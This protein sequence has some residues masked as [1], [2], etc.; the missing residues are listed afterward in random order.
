MH[1][2]PGPVDS[3]NAGNEISIWSHKPF[4]CQPWSILITGLAVVWISWLL[5]GRWWLIQIGRAH[6]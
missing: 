5:F 6:V 3:L 2:E 1:R 4:W